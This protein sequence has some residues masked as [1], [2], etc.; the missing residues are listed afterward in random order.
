MINLNSPMLYGGSMKWAC[1]IVGMSCKYCAC[2]QWGKV[3]VNIKW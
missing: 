2:Q 3:W 1:H